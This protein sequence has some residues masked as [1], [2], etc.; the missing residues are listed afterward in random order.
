MSEL[1]QRRA[2]SRGYSTGSQGKWPAHRPP[3]PPVEVVAELM[4]A[5]REV[6]DALDDE[7]AKMDDEDWEKR[8]SPMIDRIDTAMVSV[9]KWLMA[10]KDACLGS[11]SS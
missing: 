6:R 11:E 1:E 8:F 4:T 5:A 9:S 7:L 3:C 2:Y 10:G